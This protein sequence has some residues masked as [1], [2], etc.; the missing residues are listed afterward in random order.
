M[1]STTRLLSLCALLFGLFACGTEDTG[2]GDDTAPVCGNG[3][4]TR[5]E[6]CDDGNNADRDGC[7]SECE[8]QDG[9]RCVGEPSVCEPY[10][11]ECGNGIIDRDTG[12]RCDDDNTDAD[13]GC[14]ATCEVEEGYDC[15]G[16]PS[17]CDNG[18]IPDAGPDVD[19]GDTGSPDGTTDSGGTDTAVDPV[20][21]D[22]IVTTPE[23][24]DDEDDTAGDGCSDQCRTETGFSCTG[25]PSVCTPTGPCDPTACA[26]SAGPCQFASCGAD[27]ACNVRGRPEGAA[28]ATGDVCAPFGLCAA[29]ECDADPL[30]CSGLD[31]ECVRGECDAAAGGC[32]AVE[33]PEGGECGT[34]D[35]CG[36]GT[37]T[38]GLCVR[39]AEPDCT[40]CDGGTNVCMDGFCGG[41]EPVLEYGFDS[42]DLPDGLT[43]GGSAAWARDTS[44]FRTGTASFRSGDIGDSQTSDLVWTVDLTS[45]GTLSFWYEVSSES[46]CDEFMLV[47]DGATVVESASSEWT[48]VE[49]ELAAGAH[50]IIFR[51]RKDSSVSSGTDAA[52]IDDL[53]FE[54]D[55][56]ACAGDEC[57]ASVWNGS[58]CQLCPLRED[59]DECATIDSECLIQTCEA[60]RCVAEDVD[61][62]TDCA[63]GAD[64]CMSGFCGGPEPEL[65]FDFEAV[66]APVGLVGGGARGWARDTSRANTGAAS[67]R[68]GSIANSSS[69]TLTYQMTAAAAGS[70][71]F[72]Y[73]VSSEGCC[74]KL[75]FSIDGTEVLNVGGTIAFTRATFPLTAG[76]HTLVW[77]YTKDIS[78]TSG[79]DAAWIDDVVISFGDADICADSEC[80]AGVW[81]GTACSVCPTRPNGTSCDTDA[82]DCLAYA[83]DAGLCAPEPVDDCSFCGPDLANVCAAGVC[84]GYDEILIEAFEAPTLPAG[85]FTYGDSDWTAAASAGR[86]GNAFRS[87]VIGNSQQSIM[88]TSVTVD[89]A[90]EL[91]FW[92]RVDS[93]SCCDKLYFR[94]DDT[95]VFN[96]S[97]TTW[98]RHVYTL[99][100]GTHTLRW[101]YQKDSAT[102]SGVD[103]AWLDD[104]EL[105]GVACEPADCSLSV[106]D[107]TA[108]VACPAPD[109]ADCSGGGTCA[110]GTCEG[111]GAP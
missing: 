96:S 27:G 1:P 70:V 72:W 54:Y 56:G 85:F 45:A 51:Y 34:T 49:R 71:A 17:I 65:T 43:N 6:G 108:C 8:P 24:C 19:A 100:P 28:C 95:D 73:S 38:D 90:T 15:D 25:E 53:R 81:D 9:Y 5:D 101:R 33:I 46:C 31:D 39:D 18:E 77:S 42:S 63:D 41:P 32:V 16:E 55:G 29:G 99:T 88:Q 68:S 64:V 91:G 30:D 59:G 57:G 14:S 74:D 98:T 48:L 26:A 94:V 66:S 23:T 62:C 47:V 69:S 110:A 82:A 102:V 67:F 52:Y 61:D 2:A 37:C 44:N 40:L 60:G 103:A 111:S 78:S 83:C 22:G 84:G 89:V 104:V 12:E 109:G 107:G 75:R 13:D 3:L 35:D 86:T 93:E 7:N 20:C 87:G 50:T 97:A 36:S 79:T 105:P 21:G 106:S 10:D 58:A 80:G 92:F 4:V 11:P 76:S